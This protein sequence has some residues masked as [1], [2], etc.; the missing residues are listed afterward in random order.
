[1][2]F[3]FSF[4]LKSGQILSFSICYTIYFGKLSMF[5]HLSNSI[6]FQILTAFILSTCMGVSFNYHKNIR[7]SYVY[8][9]LKV[10]LTTIG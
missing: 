2:Q 1:M 8:E 5:T 4:V 10:H 6:H 9:P 7:I 3:L